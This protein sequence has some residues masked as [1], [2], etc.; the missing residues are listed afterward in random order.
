MFHHFHGEGHAPQQGSISAEKL[1]HIMSLYDVVDA[2]EWMENPRGTCLTFDDGLKSQYDVAMPVLGGVAAFVF[3]PS[4]P[5][6]GVPCNTEVYRRFRMSFSTPGMFYAQFARALEDLGYGATLDYCPDNYLEGHDF[7]TASDRWFRYVRDRVLGPEWYGEVME[8]MMAGHEVDTSNL[9]MTADDVAD[10]HDKGHIIGLHSHYHPTNMG[11]LSN[12]DQRA[13]YGA[14]YATIHNI[15]G[16]RPRT[17]SHPCN[18]YTR[19]TLRIL[20]DLDIRLGFRSN[21]TKRDHSHLEYP[22]E[23]HA[24]LCVLPSSQVTSP[25][26]SP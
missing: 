25:A 1:A 24:N 18:S 11:E 4:S 9:W 21:K 13:E 26:T 14:A 23:D 5:L 16:E 17:M 7:Y 6:V 8:A 10:L 3:P 15:T 22:R 2:R 12:A 19:H 20:E